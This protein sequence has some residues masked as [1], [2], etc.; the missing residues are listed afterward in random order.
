MRFVTLECGCFVCV[1]HKLNP[2][3]YLRKR[4][5]D[6]FEMFHRFIFRAHNEEIP[7]GYEIDHMCNNRACCNKDHL[8][9]IPGD[10]HTRHTNQT[11]Y[12][13]RYE[14]AKLHWI[15]SKVTGTKLGE[16]FGVS[17]SNACLWIRQWKAELT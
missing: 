5:V 9:A 17:I 16:I 13:E 7:E 11:R 15:E 8:R 2:D 1:S 14:A 3:G 4:W 12:L 10:E 6:V